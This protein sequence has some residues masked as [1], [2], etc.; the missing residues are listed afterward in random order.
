MG[1]RI[2]EQNLWDRKGIALS[3]NNRPWSY[4]ILNERGNI[5]ASNRRHLI[6][7]T[8]TINIK[9]DYDNVIPVSNTSTHPNL[10]IDNQHEKPTLEEVYIAKCS[11]KSKTTY[12][13]NVILFILDFWTFWISRL[14]N[15]NITICEMICLTKQ[16]TEEVWFESLSSHPFHLPKFISFIP[17]TKGQLVYF[18]I[19]FLLIQFTDH[20]PSHLHSIHIWFY[21]YCIVFQPHYV[22]QSRLWKLGVSLDKIL[23]RNIYCVPFEVKLRYSLLIHKN[24]NAAVILGLDATM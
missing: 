9:H 22:F 11:S 4:Y 21:S 23:I 2:D 20:S 16:R 17:C 3:Q 6:P 1:I 7:T 14:T 24:H 19:Y 8:K 12:W 18:V 13:C 5:L 15:Q 10:M